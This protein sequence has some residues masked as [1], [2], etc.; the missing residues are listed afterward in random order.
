MVHSVG[1]VGLRLA[2]EVEHPLRIEAL[3][4]FDEQR[5]GAECA[6]AERRIGGVIRARL[7]QDD[8]MPRDRRAAVVGAG[9]VEAV[10]A[11]L[12]GDEIEPI[13]AL[14]GVERFIGG[15]IRGVVGQDQ[16]VVGDGGFGVGGGGGFRRGAAADGGEEAQADEHGDHAQ[17]PDRNDGRH[18]AREAHPRR[19]DDRAARR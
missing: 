12:T 18:V 5:A 14:G 10:E 4:L 8:R 16:R 11:L 13:G 17:E 7:G 15:D 1:A 2:A 9:R 6:A 3:L 19:G